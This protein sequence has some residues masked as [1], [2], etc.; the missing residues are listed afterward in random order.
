MSN[1][2]HMKSIKWRRAE[3]INYKARKLQTSLNSF[4][5]FFFL[6]SLLG[7]RMTLERPLGWKQI[8]A[9]FLEIFSS[10]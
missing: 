4:C 1:F 10:L 9:I 2:R 7:L 3:N 6:P 8:F 5:E